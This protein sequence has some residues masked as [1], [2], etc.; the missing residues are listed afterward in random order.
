M[1]NIVYILIVFFIASCAKLDRAPD[2]AITTEQ[3]YQ[4]SADAVAAVNTVYTSTLNP[5]PLMMYNRLFH[6]AFE[7]QTDD[8][9][10]GQRVTNVDV[11]AMASLTQSTTNDRVDELW[12]EHYNAINQANIAI[13]KIPAISM[14]PVL[15]TRLINEAKFLRGLLYFNMVRLWGDVPLVLHE[16][17][18]LS[19]DSIQVARTPAEDVY[20]QIISDLTDAE[21]LPASYSANDLGRAT[22]GAA[23][24]ILA[25]VYLTRQEWDKAASKCLEVMTGPYGY[26]LF[27]NYA[28]VF[29]INKKNIQEQIFS[30]QCVGGNIQGNRLASSCAPV[31]IPGIP[32]AGTDEPT[33]Q[34]YQ[35]FD[36]LDLRRDVTFDT[37][38][39]SPTNGQTYK[40]TP[41][42]AKYWDPTT[43][44]NPTNSN[45]NIPVIRYAEVLLMYA[46]ALNEVNHGPTADAYDAVNKVI[47]RA[48]GKTIDVPDSTVDLK[49]LDYTG[50]QQAVYLQRRKELM[51]EFQRWF[52]LIR[53]KTMVETLHAVGKTA[54]SDKNYL[55]PVPQ[56]EI[57]LNPKLTQ[58]PGW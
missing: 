7:I 50:F 35:I 11:R 48:Y 9:I 17:T 54:A 2:S 38:L 37:S 13:D 39:I 25:K 19:Q 42:F 32:A 12:K 21:N 33:T 20:A 26:S 16:T 30:A 51:M 28:D 31:G 56:H 24:S 41:H 52:D 1:K 3:F 23:K 57:D 58:N 10:A 49:D 27:P 53:T 34:A 4:T 29:N 46:E 45:Q 15:Q 47:R 8:A 6:L 40:F 36:S 18:S 44:T 43:I 22:G 55:L 14:D 5:G